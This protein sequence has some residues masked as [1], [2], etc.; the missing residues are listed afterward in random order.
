MTLCDAS[1]VTLG[2][3][4]CWVDLTHLLFLALT[5]CLVGHRA[6]IEVLNGGTERLDCLDRHYCLPTL[7]VD[8]L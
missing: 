5:L 1:G 8:S 2:S 7:S 6:V 4:E 3:L